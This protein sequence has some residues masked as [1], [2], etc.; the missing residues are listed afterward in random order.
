[1]ELVELLA[2]VVQ[3]KA[4]ELR[5]EVGAP[6]ALD[7]GGNVRELSLPKPDAKYFDEMVM[8]ELGQGARAT[9]ANL[10]RCED[11]LEI[12]GIGKFRVLVEPGKAR[13]VRIV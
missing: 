13:F 3:R 6:I 5:L 2:L 4:T 11:V 7:V 9:L 10:G 12:K 8:Q 1:M